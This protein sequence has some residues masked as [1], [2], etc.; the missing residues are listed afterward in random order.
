MSQAPLTVPERNA[1]L[2]GD[3]LAT[4][5]G[6]EQRGQVRQGDRLRGLWGRLTQP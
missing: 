3:Y 2:L 4:K 1:S 6:I 5:T